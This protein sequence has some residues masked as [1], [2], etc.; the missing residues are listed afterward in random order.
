MVH[1]TRPIEDDLSLLSV[2][3]RPED[4]EETVILTG[5]EPYHTLRPELLRP[6]NVTFSIQDD[7]KKL[8]AMCGAMP[9]GREGAGIVWFLARPEIEQHALSLTKQAGAY[10]DILSIPYPMGLTALLWE[11]NEMHL[12]W[13]QA[14]GF[15]AQTIIEV[16]DD[17]EPFILI[18]RPRR[19]LSA[20]HPP[21]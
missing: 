10:L 4:R 18:H 8:L 16:G 5:K 17:F 1:F 3:L 19:E 7:D 6:P 20:P 9:H 15:T 2:N 12:R 11:K 13:S 21:S 14:V